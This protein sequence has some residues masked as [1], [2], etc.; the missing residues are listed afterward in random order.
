MPFAA[1]FEFVVPVASRSR[2]GGYVVN[3]YTPCNSW[4]LAQ[5]S[6]T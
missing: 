5:W 4:N 1:V 3:P 6:V 2:V